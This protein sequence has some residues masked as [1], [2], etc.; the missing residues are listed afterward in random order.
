ASLR[1]EADVAVLK[2]YEKDILPCMACDICPSRVGPDEE[3]RCIRGKTDAMMDLHNE[4]LKADI[5]IPA[6]FSPKDRDGLASAYQNFLERTRYL[7][8]G[9]YAFTD[10]LIAPLVIA[11][12]GTQENLNLR[13]ATSLIRHQ[14]V[15]QKPITGWLHKGELLN[16]EDVRTGFENAVEY[17]RKLVAGRLAMVAQGA[18]VA[19][20]KPLGYVLS[21]SKDNMPETMSKR[22]KAIQLR[23][24]R[25][26][27]EGRN[28]LV[29]L[30]NKT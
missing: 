10:R 8:R 27:E 15:L 12:V 3:F 2:M 19:L 13:M 30:D 20:Y 22:E 29:S 14:T 5:L 1:M 9:D 25:L 11:E 7:R 23:I 24:Q 26:M 6:M 17:G 28:R 21:L 16:P 4:I 18:P